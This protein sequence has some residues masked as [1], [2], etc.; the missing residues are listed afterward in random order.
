METHKDLEKILHDKMSLEELNLN[1]PAPFLIQDAR[2]KIGTRKKPS[3]EPHDFFS[4]IAAFLNL[5]VK[6][7]Q[8]VVASLIIGGIIL[9]FNREDSGGI[10]T[11]PDDSV[12]NIASVRSS[13]V[14]SSIYTFGLNKK[15]L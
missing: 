10:N 9:T 12:S 8:A 2:K 15:P 7:Y 5:K 1:D 4:L 6:L 11:R 3:V 14:L 13:T